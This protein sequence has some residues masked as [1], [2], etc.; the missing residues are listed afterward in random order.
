[1]EAVAPDRQLAGR[2]RLREQIGAGGMATVWRADDAVLARAVAVKVLHAHLADDG[3]LLERFRREAVA[4]ARLA[5]P[6]L[7]RVYDAGTDAGSAFIVMEL[8]PGRTLADVI[9]E[10]PMDPA[11]AADVTMSVLSA[12]DCAHA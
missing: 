11:T 8:V 4:A 7:V 1:M 3:S 9:R 12:L 10:G 6:N 2:Y 5:H